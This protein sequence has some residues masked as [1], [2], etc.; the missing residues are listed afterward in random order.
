M[1]LY[2]LCNIIYAL[3]K[4]IKNLKYDNSLNYFSYK[5]IH[6]PKRSYR[7]TWTTSLFYTYYRCSYGQR[8]VSLKPFVDLFSKYPHIVYVRAVY[9]VMI[10][11]FKI[12]SSNKLYNG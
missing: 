6:L 4:F 9:Y 3:C 8:Q 1:F 11:N 5:N 2:L 10:I 12:Q 7:I